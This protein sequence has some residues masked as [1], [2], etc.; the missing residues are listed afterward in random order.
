[1]TIIYTEFLVITIAKKIVPRPQVC[2]YYLLVHQDVARIFKGNG[3]WETLDSLINVR[4]NLHILR[5]CSYVGIV[6]VMQAFGKFKTLLTNFHMFY[7][8]TRLNISSKNT[9]NVQCSSTI[10]H[11]FNFYNSRV[12]Y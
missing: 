7:T 4:Y 10:P 11:T 3:K 12:R 1:M 2:I 6:F 9:I 5:Y 8:Y